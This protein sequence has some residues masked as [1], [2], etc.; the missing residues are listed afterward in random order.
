M[1]AITKP[2]APGWQS[3]TPR[4]HKVKPRNVSP[5]SGVSQ[6]YVWAGE[7]WTFTFALPPI[8]NPTTAQSWI[9]FLYDLARD[10][11]Y[12][13]CDVSAYVPSSVTGASTKHLR[14]TSPDA[15]WDIN[16]AKLFGITFEAELD[17]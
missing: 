1:A 8:K 12:F 16:T 9:T 10:D 13:V 4:Y 2:S 15:S 14:L 11:N 3:V 17:Q 5:F 7:N 6:T